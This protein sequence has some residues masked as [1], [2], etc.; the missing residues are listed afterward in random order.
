[1]RLERCWQEGMRHFYYL[2]EEFFTIAFFHA[3][4]CLTLSFERLKRPLTPD[5]LFGKKLRGCS[6]VG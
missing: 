1:M 6:S 3:Q 5:K 2:F 4:L